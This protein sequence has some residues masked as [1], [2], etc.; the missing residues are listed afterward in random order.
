M[1]AK[2]VRSAAAVAFAE[3]TLTLSAASSVQEDGT[4][5]MLPTLY[6]I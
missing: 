6:G 2:A 3:H 1:T 4:I 5:H